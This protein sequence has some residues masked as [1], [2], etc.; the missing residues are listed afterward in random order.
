V[1][2]TS[3]VD[4]RLAQGPSVNLPTGGDALRSDFRGVQNELATFIER[5]QI[6]EGLVVSLLAGHN[7]LPLGPP[8]TAKSLLAQSLC[9]RLDGGRYFQR[10]LTKF[11]TPEELFGPLKIS[12]L[13]HDRFERATAGYLPEAHSAFLDEIFKGG[14]AILN[15][16]LTLLN[17]RIFYNGT[18]AR[19]CPLVMV[20][21][22]SNEYGDD[23]VEALYDRFLLRFEV[24]YVDD[25]NAAALLS[26]V[27]PPCNA[28]F[29]LP[30]LEEARRAVKEIG[31]SDDILKTLAR[32]RQQLGLN[33]IHPSDR[34]LRQC[35]DILRAKAWLDGVAVADHHLLILEQ[36]LW[37][38]QEDREKIAEVLVGSLSEEVLKA[39]L[40]LEKARNG[41]RDMREKL[42]D[43]SRRT[44]LRQLQQGFVEMT[45]ALMTELSDLIAHTPASYVPSIQ[46]IKATLQDMRR[47]VVDAER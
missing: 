42:R 27:T 46:E 16:M 7:V 33:G 25:R 26:F 17:E 47:D 14:S 43:E 12:G 11:T 39:R 30:Q 37:S 1:A 28:R 13:Q 2:D 20:V 34:R 5:E 21:G 15:T 29:T 18:E 38:K 23:D 35:L 22:A 36:A 32:V 3:Q 45:D 44:R 10:L 8:G 41:Y 40:I 4:S 6:A 24:G 9:E 31:V 19:R